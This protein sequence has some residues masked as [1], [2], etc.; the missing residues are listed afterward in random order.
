MLLYHR[1]F[2]CSVCKINTVHQKPRR[3]IGYELIWYNRVRGGVSGMC[4]FTYIT[5][6]HYKI[7]FNITLL[8]F[9]ITILLHVVTL[10]WNKN[11][12]VIIFFKGGTVRCL[13]KNQFTTQ[14]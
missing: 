4:V 1:R 14:K 3:Q 5:V 6:T 10:K 13:L 12:K 2:K 9:T 8:I 7:Q 11:F